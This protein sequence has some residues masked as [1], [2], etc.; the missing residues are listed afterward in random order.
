MM[1]WFIVRPTPWMVAPPWTAMLFAQ[2]EPAANT[3]REMATSWPERAVYW[4]VI[5]F[6]YWRLEKHVSIST[7]RLVASYQAQSAAAVKLSEA[8]AVIK[9]IPQKLTESQEAFRECEQNLTGSMRNLERAVEL[10][11]VQQ[12]HLHQIQPQQPPQ[13]QQDQSVRGGGSRY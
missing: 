3:I 7:E 12:P 5:A 2:V 6:L 8:V 11:R 1:L 13:P 4:I 10:W 9:E